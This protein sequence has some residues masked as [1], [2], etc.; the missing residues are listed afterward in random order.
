MSIYSSFESE[1]EAGTPDHSPIVVLPLASAWVTPL[2]IVVNIVVFLLQTVAGGSTDLCTLIQFGAKFNLLIRAGQYWRLFTPVFLH[3]GI[4]HLIFN[5]YALWIVGRDVERLFGSVRF[6]FIYFL[7]GVWG[8]IVS[9]MFSN[10]ISAGAS[11]AIF[12]LVGAEVAFFWRNREQFGEVGRRQIFN[13]L[14]IVAL[15]LFFGLSVEGIDNWGH[16]GGLLSGFLF[17]SMLAPRYAVQPLPFNHFAFVDTNPLR[18]RLW[19][20]IGVV[21]V[22]LALVP[23]LAGLAPVRSQDALLLRLCARR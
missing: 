5:Q 17:G 3:V 18:G 7:A 11:G 19:W 23:V 21:V 10:A 6:V 15:N 16:I 13:L 9:M 20:V 14:V 22:T 4:L 2:L 8:S 1:T 12:G